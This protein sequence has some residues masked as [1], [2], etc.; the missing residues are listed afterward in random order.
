MFQA[1][2]LRRVLKD[3]DIQLHLALDA[4]RVSQLLESGH[5]APAW[6]GGGRADPPQ[7]KRKCNK[8]HPA[9]CCLL[10]VGDAHHDIGISGSRGDWAILVNAKINVTQ[11]GADLVGVA[12]AAEDRPAEIIFE[13]IGRPVSRKRADREVLMAVADPPRHISSVIAGEAR[14]EPL[15]PCPGDSRI[16]KGERCTP[17][18]LGAAGLSWVAQVRREYV[19]HIGILGVEA[20]CARYGA[21]PRPVECN[22]REVKHTVPVSG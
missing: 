10:R 7:T 20:A 5:A 11:A 19:R 2:W 17:G 21:V 12:T 16:G 18:V 3:G 9:Y 6:R 4:A 15:D 1:R 22:R 8:A 13:E 14:I